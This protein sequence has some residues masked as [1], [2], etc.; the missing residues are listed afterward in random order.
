MWRS[1][2]HISLY[3][4]VQVE[5]REN[6]AGVCDIKISH[7]PE[8]DIVMNLV[9][10]HALDRTAPPPSFRH[11]MTFVAIAFLKEVPRFERGIGLVK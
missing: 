5:Y 2:A 11:Q 1:L 8:P 9:K 7:S 6:V 10:R 4:W 3:V